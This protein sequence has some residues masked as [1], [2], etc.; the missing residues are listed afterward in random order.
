MKKANLIEESI[1]P[2]ASPVVCVPKAD[3]SLRVCINFRMVNRDIINDAYPMHRMEEQLEAMA[4][5]TVFTTL[6]LTKGYHQLILHPDSK[7]ITAFATP[8]GLY[9][10]KV[11][12]QGMKTAGAVFQRVMDHIMGDLQPRCVSVYI[13]D[14]TVYSP[15]M[16]Q[17]LLDL[18]AV[19]RRLEEANLKVSISKTKL[20]QPEVLVLGHIV[21]AQG[22]RP[23]PDRVKGLG[24]IKRPS[25][26]KE[27]RQFVG[28][29]NFYRRFIPGC[30][31][32]GEGLFRLTRKEERFSWGRDQEEA[33]QKL[34]TALCSAP[35]LRFPDWAKQF[36]IET[37]ASQVGIGAALTQE[38]E[39]EIRLPVA[40]A[41]RSLNDTERRYSTTDREGLAVIWAVKYFMSYILGMPFT[42]VTDHSALTALKT[43]EKLEGRLQ[44]WAEFLS[45]YDYQILYRRGVENHIPDL[46][47]RALLALAQQIPL[48]KIPPHLKK[49]YEMAIQRNRHWVRPEARHAV[50]TDI[51]ARWGGHL[52]YYRFWGAVSAR[53][54]W[55]SIRRDVMEIL[56]QCAT[57]QQFSMAKARW[58]IRPIS[59]SFPFEMVSMDTG[60]VSMSSGRMEY[61]VL[62]IDHF[63]KWVEIHAMT[64]ETGAALA[65]FLRHSIIFRHG[66]PEKLL[67]DNGP[68]YTSQD[69]KMECQKWGLR[70]YTSAPYHPQTNGLIERT[71]G[72]IKRSAERLAGGDMANWR[73]YYGQA[74]MAYRM[75][76]H[77]DTGFS[78]F[79]LLYGREATTSQELGTKTSVDL[80]S[81]AQAVELH[82][83]SI[84]KAFREAESRSQNNKAKRAARWRR[85]P[86]VVTPEYKEGDLV[87]FDQRKHEKH[88]RR[89]LQRWIGPLRVVMKT[90]GPNYV[91][92]TL[93]DKTTDIW[94]RIHPEF[95]KPFRGERG[96]ARLPASPGHPREDEEGSSV[97]NDGIPTCDN[98]VGSL[99]ITS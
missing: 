39:E 90:A 27:V 3:G 10:W 77:S 40:Y 48:R 91:L 41:S 71:I 54:W 76:P 69:F 36:F 24:E 96:D 59:V 55:P 63:T 49:E 30:S 28:A 80:E 19:F 22:I 38:H 89:G 83:K 8:D 45:D 66:C 29:V 32:L 35:V 86:G 78:P 15:T 68:A 44:R 42:I 25:T 62:A 73:E 5:S 33:F 75:T 26:P 34:L 7:H 70:K 2:Y 13:D 81:Y 31:T 1:S 4:G 37:D 51:H 16:E 47:S 11:L 93:D 79:R 64:Q 52:R 18:D 60:Y 6:D 88:P 56:D 95:L 57:C 14:I 12:P 58:G 97:E 92:Q 20:A 87:W 84:N 61:F 85:L 21:S 94:K 46:L 72:T 67:T 82:T 23:N 9:Q 65:T 99:M 74:V 17:H 98:F 53:Y 43:K 50:L